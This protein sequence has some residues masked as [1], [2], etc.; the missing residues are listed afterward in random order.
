MENV[1]PKTKLKVHVLNLLKE[2][3]KTGIGVIITD[4]GKPVAKIIRYAEDSSDILKSLR[5]SVIRYDAPTM[6][7]GLEDWDA[8]K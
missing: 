7:V 2:I 1:I 8:L 3:E 6:P 5:N 4:K